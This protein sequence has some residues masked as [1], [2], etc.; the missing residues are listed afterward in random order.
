MK[1]HLLGILLT[2]AAC[3]GAYHPTLAQNTKDIVDRLNTSLGVSLPSQ[4]QTTVKNFVKNSKILSD[5]DAQT[6]TE[7][8]IK[9]QMKTSWGINKQNQLLFVWDAVY[10]Q[11]LNNKQLYTGEDGNQARLDEFEKVM[12]KAE[13]CGK[14]YKEGFHAYMEQRSAEADR[15]SAE[16]DRRSA[17][18]DRRSAEADRRSAEADRRSAEAERRSAEAERRSAEAVQRSV[19]ST[20]GGLYQLISY[21]SLWKVAP[22]SARK[23]SELNETKEYCKYEIKNCQKYN[24][25]YQSLLPLE[26]QK[27]YDIEPAAK[28]RNTITCDKAIVQILNIVLQEIVKL[29]NLYQKA[30]QAKREIRDIKDYIKDCKE[31]NIDYKSKLSPE[32]RRFFGVE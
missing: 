21:Y 24:I 30:P 15:R 26:V 18:A 13:A 28:L 19:I 25:D 7:Q 17:E 3:F 9:E 31:H 22:E 1:Q 5:K 32:V 6:F 20:Y 4:Y 14:K 23:E 12:E 2:V 27:F 10:G 16:A 11:I 8:F 29:Y